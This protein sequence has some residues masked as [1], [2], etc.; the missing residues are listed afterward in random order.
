MKKIL[1]ILIIIT[2]L[3]FSSCH[4]FS[5]TYDP[6]VGL[7]AY[8]SLEG[9]GKNYADIFN[10]ATISNGELVEGHLGTD[11]P[12]S[13]YYLDGS[14]GTYIQ[15]GSLGAIS[16]AN[17]Y[18]AISFW[19]KIAS[20][21]SSSTTNCL[22]GKTGDE[23]GYSVAVFGGTI[24]FQMY[25]E[26]GDYIGATASG[27]YDDDSWHLLNLKAV[28]DDDY[29]GVTMYI[30]K[31]AVASDGDDGVP[32]GNDSLPLYIGAEDSEDAGGCC[33]NRQH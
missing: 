6:Y 1:I 12:D 8:Y 26:D 4:E 3:V 16:E 13:A 24:S 30:D 29:T 9:D 21:D 2:G 20:E 23:V 22:I 7:L 32:T 10:T 25:L 19:F 33:Y 5:S 11:D 27:S 17:P 15:C 28:V 31:T 14:S 18:M